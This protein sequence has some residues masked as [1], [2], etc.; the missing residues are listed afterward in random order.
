MKSLKGITAIILTTVVLLCSFPVSAKIDYKHTDHTDLA[1]TAVTEG[2]VLLK[3]DNGA[4]PLAK[5]EKIALFGGGQIYT[6]STSSGYQIGGG[7]SGWV[8]SVLGTPMG[9]AEALLEAE[10]LGKVSVYKP[11]Y[12]AYKADVSYIP[13]DTMYE[14]AAAFADTAIM[15]ITRF[16]SEDADISVN[17][18]Y[19]TEAEETMMKKLSDSFEKVVVILNTPSVISADWS[20]DGNSLGVETDALL[21][22]YMGGQKG[23]EGMAQILTGDVNPSGKLTHTYARDIYDYPTTQTFLESNIYVDYKEDVY[24]GYRY[25]ETFANAK[26]KVAYPFGYGLSYTDFE[27]TSSPV[28]VSNGKIVLNVTVRN[29]GAVAG[30]EVVQVYYSAPQAGTGDAVLS[31]SAISLATYA[32]TNLL[33]PGESQTLTLSYNVSDMASFDDTGKTGNPNSYVL[34][35]GDYGIRV[36]NSVRNT[37]SA[38][39]YTVN[40]LTV[41]SEHE[42]LVATAL[43]NRLTYDGSYED[44]PVRGDT[45]SGDTD[46]GKS[47]NGEIDIDSEID[48]NADSY[49]GITYADVISG[50]AT[51]KELVAQMSYAELIGL[52]YGHEEGIVSGPGSIGFAS[53]K[54][55]EKYGVYSADTAD[56]P[57]GLRL[58]GG[59]SVATFWPCATL[60][61]S[62]W[63]TV[64]LE[65]IGKAI[66]DECL[67]YNADIWLAPGINIH[68]N[69]LC[70][71]NF[72]YYS[73]DPVVSGKSA[74]AVVNGVQ[75]KGVGCAI[76]HF[77]LNNKEYNR[78]NS[79]SR[80]SEKAMREIYLKGFEI[81]IEDANPMCVMTAYNLVNGIH[82]SANSELINGILRGEWG[83]TG[84]IMS[85]WNTMPSNLREVAAGNNVK[86]PNESGDP[87]ALK[88]AVKDGSLSRETLENNAMFII[89][90]LAKLPDNTIHAKYVNDISAE[91]MTTISANKYSKKAYQIKFDLVGD[92]MCASHT[93][94]A[95]EIDGSRGFIEFTVSVNTPGTYLLAMNYATIHNVGAAFRIQINGKNV[96]GLNSNVA[97]T[98]AWDKFEDKMLGEIHLD[99]GISTVRIQHLSGSG[100]NYHTLSTMLLEADK[101]HEHSFDKFEAVDE[102]YHKLSCECGEEKIEAHRWDDGEIITE[103]TETAE[104]EI[105]FTCEECA[106]T[107]IE[108]QPKL[109]AEPTSEPAKKGIGAKMITVISIVLGVAVIATGATVVTV[110]IKK[111][112]K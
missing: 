50:K 1:L 53:N 78:K 59:A 46:N 81:A 85:D 14:S 43:A 33:A 23:G 84:L 25:F 7:G 93:E 61:A 6:A 96:F 26:D 77:A 62:T 44:L 79:D 22:C 54:S 57:A 111:T 56:G 40:T 2:I 37:E 17:E 105:R 63:N 112:K 72:E 45:T 15:F 19:L 20:I 98:G 88:K 47:E 36:G 89:N 35:A 10:K 91:G 100:V 70:G 52:C 4:L 80:V 76:K 87:E 18:W 27:I 34:E 71:R 99:K 66:G 60:Q 106:H 69:P 49:K 32:K 51:L 101:P 38:G 24:V 5:N 83:Y 28:T 75:A 11:L 29:I 103:A 64:L 94:Y 3:N 16:S 108:I 74:A 110:K 39:K 31:K 86:M 107:A 58:S 68:K 48:M 73:E 67:R 42:R 13:D 102:Q 82:A 95:D 104:G 8:S 12:D 90:T 109:P 97:S 55:A 9:P 41:V 21:A 92:S 30:K 65:E